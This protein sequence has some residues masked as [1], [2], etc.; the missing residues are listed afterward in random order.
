VEVV[1]HPE[2]EDSHQTGSVYKHIATLKSGDV[3]GE[4]GLLRQVPRS[5]TVIAHEPAELLQVNLRMIQRLQWLYPPT[6]QKF[7]FNLMNIICDRLEVVTHCLSDESAI[8]DLTG[9]CTRR[10]FSEELSKEVDRC[11]R[12]RTDLSLCLL[13]LEARPCQASARPV[14]PGTLRDV[15]AGLATQLRRCD[16]I[17]HISPQTFALLLPHTPLDGAH[18]LWVR[19]KDRLCSATD[20]A[21]KDG[22]RFTM[23][24]SGMKK[25]GETDGPDLDL[26]IMDPQH[27]D[28]TV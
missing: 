8:D 2:G 4:M 26:R 27:R 12:Y 15:G 9:L 6:A 20:L 5:A 17:G 1:D 16:T 19:I 18:K 14:E 3:L 23:E 24:F 21:K 22:L 11:R 10:R 13:T 7:F 28:K 25:G